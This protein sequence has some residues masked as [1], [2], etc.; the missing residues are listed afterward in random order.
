M[1]DVKHNTASDIAD[2]DEDHSFETDDENNSECSDDEEDTTDVISTG[3]NSTAILKN[4]QQSRR[5]TTSK[6]LSSKFL[7]MKDIGLDSQ[8]SLTSSTLAAIDNLIQR[9]PT[10]PT[11]V[12][13]PPEPSTPAYS[14]VSS[15][16]LKAVSFGF[17]SLRRGVDRWGLFSPKK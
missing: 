9:F 12:P 14:Q 10:A 3:D 4:E 8:I 5:P 11:N 1:E 13:Q 7:P 15:A 16:A 6:R 17:G 2:G